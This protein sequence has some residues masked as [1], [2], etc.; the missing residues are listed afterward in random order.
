MSSVQSVSTFGSLQTLLQNMGEV[1]NSLS[2]SQEAISSGK[3]SQT[4]DGMASDVQQLTSISAQVTR[5][6][7]YQSGNATVIGQM[8][9]TSTVLGQIQNIASSLKS[10][11]QSQISGTLSGA[12]FK[13]Q[14]KSQVEALAAALNTNYGGNFIFAGAAT[15]APPIKTPVPTNNAVG[16]PDASY[17]QGSTLDPQVRISDSQLITPG[18][19]G[20]ELAFQQLFAGMNQALTAPDGA[21]GSDIL[22]ASE[23]LI[24]KGMQGVIT[25][26]SRVNSNILTVQQ[27][28][29]QAQSVQTYYTGIVNS[30]TNADEIS[31]SAKVAQDTTVLQAS[32]ATFARISQLSLVNFLK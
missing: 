26:Q 11:V 29:T 16:V 24:D 7:N 5:I 18:V 28:N 3:A 8:Q 30:L 19:N 27:S 1:Q 6:T 20:S 2:T 17:Y 23:N 13:Q 4:F 15:S 22:T 9:T 12:S 21:S 31:L 25:L 32:F 14:V 10:L